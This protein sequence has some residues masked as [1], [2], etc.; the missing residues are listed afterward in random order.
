M[1]DRRLVFLSLVEMLLKRC[2][3]QLQTFDG[4]SHEA[5]SKLKNVGIFF[6]REV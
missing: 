2:D 3:G 6:S 5:F 4:G 1:L